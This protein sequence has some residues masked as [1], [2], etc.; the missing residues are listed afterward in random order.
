MAGPG[1][2]STTVYHH[3]RAGA[4]ESDHKDKISQ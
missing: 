3:V 4:T 1:L 2:P